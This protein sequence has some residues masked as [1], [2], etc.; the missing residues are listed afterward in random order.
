MSP[1]HRDL[2]QCVGF[3]L[4][5]TKAQCVPRFGG[6]QQAEAGDGWAVG[7]DRGE[8]WSAGRPRGERG[9]G[10][11]ARWV[12]VLIKSTHGLP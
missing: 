12:T 3:F 2:L 10:P 11:S 4:E 1:L 9:R 5:S 8:A 6:G 7:R